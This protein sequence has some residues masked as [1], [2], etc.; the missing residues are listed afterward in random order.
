MSRIPLVVGIVNVTPDSFSDGGRIGNVEEAVA[1]GK[2]LVEQGADI[3]DIG[4]ES[5]RPGAERV[6]AATE[7]QRVLP[8]IEGLRRAGVRVSISIDT[9]KADVA[10]AALAAGATIVNDVTAGTGD[11]RMFEV[12]ARRG[13]D[14]VLMHMNGEPGTMQKEPHYDDVVGEVARFLVEQAQ[15]AERAGISSSRISIDPGIGFGKTFA[16]NE[17]LLRRLEIFAELG[18]PVWL[19]A[20]RKGFLGAI[21]G[22][23][24]GERLAASLACA[25]RG[26]F[27]GVAAVRVHDVA[28]TVDL[29]RVLERIAPESV[30]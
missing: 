26:F 30:D 14:I 25:A 6:D 5:T 21:T 15:A 18:Y 1:F 16:H 4:G 2:R 8:V 20:S 7:R 24:V 27:A 17:E 12:V 29:L 28:E 23:P 19:G 13:A 10:D 3:L 22:C 9:R 11:P